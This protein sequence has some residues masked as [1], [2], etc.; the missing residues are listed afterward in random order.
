[1]ANIIKTF[2]N[3]KSPGTDGLPIEFYKI[4]WNDVKNVLLNSIN[5]AYENGHLSISEC[6]GI[7]TLLPKKDKDPLLLKNW[8]PISFLNTDYKMSWI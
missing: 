4:F 2:Q 1:M 6:Q 5:F 7:I 3:N 8:R